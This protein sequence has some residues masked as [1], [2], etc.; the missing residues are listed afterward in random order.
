MTAFVLGRAIHFA[1][2][3][4]LF[5]CPLFW[6]VAGKEARL[7]SPRSFRATVLLLRIAAPLAL[8]SGVV[9][10]L[11]IVAN[12][13][14]GMS[15]LDA[16]SLQAFFFQTQ[17]GPVAILRLVL[18]TAAAAIALLTRADRALLAGVFAAATLLLLDQ[19]WLGHAAE[20]GAS[21]HGA[22]MILAY[23]VHM[24]AG[25]AWVG[26]LAP[27]LLC[28]AQQRGSPEARTRS[29]HILA[30]FSLLGIFAVTA[31]VVS[32]IANALF[33]DAGAKFF[34]TAYGEVLGL[35]LLLVAAMLALASFNRFVAMPRLRADPFKARAHEVNL[36]ISV[37]L[38]LT[39]GLMVVAVAALLGLTPP[40]H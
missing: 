14:G 13:A 37:G 15:D 8:V 28:L 17:F 11:G 24:F 21:L 18:L 25:A 36:R 7:G 35:K 29:L 34:R 4:A 32:G 31:V 3:F 5:G 38:E 33:H 10:L 12:M 39:F 20:G 1:A 9:W 19:A 40:P 26:G 2:L 27:L 6:L 22:L 23:A 16:A 30:R